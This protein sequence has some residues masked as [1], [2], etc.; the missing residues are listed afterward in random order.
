MRILRFENLTFEKRV[1]KSENPGFRREGAL[2]APHPHNAVGNGDANHCRDSVGGGVNELNHR[3]PPG[4]H[5]YHRRCVL[6][7]HSLAGA[8]YTCRGERR[9]MHIGTHRR[10]QYV[11]TG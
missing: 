2:S 6:R 8:A 5:P 4:Y 1:L 7:L 9:R 11:R 3:F 10:R